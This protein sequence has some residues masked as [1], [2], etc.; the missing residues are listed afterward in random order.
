MSTKT[1]T[2][3]IDIV[4]S[5]LHHP[6]TLGSIKIVSNAPSSALDFRYCTKKAVMPRKKDIAARNLTDWTKFTTQINETTKKSSF[7]NATI[8]CFPESRGYQPKSR[9]KSCRLILF[10]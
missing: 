3:G 1:C 5:I 4:L 6:I 2:T 10:S 9:V 8:L 7:S